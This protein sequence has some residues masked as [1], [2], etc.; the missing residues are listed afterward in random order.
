M[1]DNPEAESLRFLAFAMVLADE[2]YEAF[3][4]AD[5]ADAESAVV[6]DGLDG[7]VRRKLVAS[8]P[9]LAHKERELLGKRCLLEVE[10]VV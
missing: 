7:V 4:E 1:A 6:D 2:G 9:E 3:C 5:E 8:G 10:A